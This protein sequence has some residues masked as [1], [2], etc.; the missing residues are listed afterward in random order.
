MPKKT[1][2]KPL[3]QTITPCLW[4][5]DQAETA[6]KYYVSVFKKNSRITAITHYPEAG[7]DVHGRKPGSVMTVA[8]EL[9]GHTFTALNGGPL[10]KFTEAISLQVNCD[11]QKEIDRFWRQLSQGGRTSQCGWLKDKFGLS[12][13]VVPRGMEDIMTDPDLEKRERA[14]MV[15]M[16]STKLNIAALKKAVAGTGKGRRAKGR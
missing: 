7:Q 10:F 13:Q 8:F 5:D 15:V 14:M 4:F 6:A 9:D 3:V 16:Q 1:A 12:W 11:T 2:R